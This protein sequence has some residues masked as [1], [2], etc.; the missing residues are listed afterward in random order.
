MGIFGINLWRK[1]KN[2]SGKEEHEGRKSRKKSKK[3]IEERA[4]KTR[5]SLEKMKIKQQ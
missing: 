2:R 4:E 5:K 3:K 1:I